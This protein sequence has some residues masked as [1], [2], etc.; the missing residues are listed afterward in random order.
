MKCFLA[1]YGTSICG[2]SIL[3]VEHI[4]RDCGLA[5]HDANLKR[6][7]EHAREVNLR[8]NPN[9]CR[10]CLDQVGCVGHIFTNE[11]LKAAPSKTTAITD[12]PV[13]SDITALQHFL[14]MVNYIGKY[15]PNLS[16][17]ATPPKKLTHKKTA[18]FWFQQHQEEFNWLKSCL[19]STPVLYDTTV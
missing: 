9:K 19:S 2:L 12:M 3:I 11:S 10:F 4:I 16:D 18:W 14:G 15:T 13:P 17:F 7:L 1:L 6:V 8:L 5:E